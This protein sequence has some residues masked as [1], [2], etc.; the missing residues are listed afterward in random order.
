MYPGVS[1]AA[2]KGKKPS[3]LQ[4][5]QKM[6]LFELELL[7]SLKTVPESESQQSQTAF[8]KVEFFIFSSLL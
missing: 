7:K 2:A 1:A 6:L 3:E 5:I 8:M 4:H